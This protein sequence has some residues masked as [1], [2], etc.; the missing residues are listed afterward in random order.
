MCIFRTFFILLFYDLLFK[1][2]YTERKKM[3]EDMI[4][5]NAQLRTL[6][7]HQEKIREEERKRVAGELHDEL[8]QLITSI[9]IDAEWL[10]KKIGDEEIELKKKTQDIIQLSS[11]TAKKVRHLAQALRPSI[12]DDMGLIPALEWQF[13]DFKSRTGIEAEFYHS[14]DGIKLSEEISTHVFRIVQESLTN[15]IRH[16]KAKKVICDMTIH[17]GKLYL[18]I[19]DNGVGFN[20]SEKKNTFGLLGIKERIKMVGGTFTINSDLGQGTESSLEIPISN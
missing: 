17:N 3:Q 2:P 16:S 12:L 4:N 19:K 20:I 7:A 18:F 11:E 13:H 14:V 15:I 8:G 6:S 5:I 1:P 9:K 10:N